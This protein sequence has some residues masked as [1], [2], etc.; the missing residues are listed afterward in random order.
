MLLSC[1]KIIML[2]R[3]EYVFMLLIQVNEPLACFE[4]VGKT[5]SLF[6]RKRGT[7]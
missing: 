6:L 2:C 7:D 4:R 5:R 1:D 3:M